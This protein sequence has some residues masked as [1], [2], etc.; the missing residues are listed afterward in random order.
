MRIAVVGGAGF[1]GGHVVD[2]LM[3]D[4]HDVT[5]MDVAP[6]RWHGS[7]I[8]K[9]LD[10]TDRTACLRAFNGY[11]VVMHLAAVSNTQMAVNEPHL[12]THI[13]CL[14]TVNVLDGA[15][16]AD[17]DR[18]VV[19]GSSLVSAY[20]TSE[21]VNSEGKVDR[22]DEFSAIDPLASY[23]PYV[24]S[25]VFTEMIARD[26]QKQYSLPVTVFRYGIQYGPRMTPG[27]VVHT[28]IERALQGKPLVV[29]GDGSQWRQYIHVKDVAKAHSQVLEQWEETAGG[30]YNL[31]TD[32]K[33]S[34]MDIAKA[35]QSCINVPIEH[36]PE[37]SGD[38]EVKWMDSEV[39]REALDWK[40]QMDLEQGI[41]NTIEWYRRHLSSGIKRP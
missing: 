41:A 21:F 19:A 22:A 17:V 5:I 1:V 40:P 4:R 9:Q 35:V 13:N 14:G 3:Q 29:H 8:F 15:R 23:H 38:I 31:V 11:Q 34:I 37:R 36:G 12:A 6:S 7:A 24:T 18:V 30:T 33:V 39:T 27:V 32:R 28:F 10:V 20:M 16:V 26:Y 2:R 25:K